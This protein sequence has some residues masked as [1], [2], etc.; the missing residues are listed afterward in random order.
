MNFNQMEF[1]QRIK[2]LRIERSLTQQSMAD[3]LNI[4]YEH[5]KK[6]EN[7]SHGCSISLLLD[8]STYFEISTDFLLMG[9]SFGLLRTKNRLAEINMILEEVIKELN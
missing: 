5:Y 8:I 3:I 6:I 2:D 7:G 4:S 9:K 1:G